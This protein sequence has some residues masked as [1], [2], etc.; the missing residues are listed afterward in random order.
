MVWAQTST[1]PPKNRRLRRSLE[2][3][4][5]WRPPRSSAAG[6]CSGRSWAHWRSFG[7]KT[8]RKRRLTRM[9]NGSTRFNGYVHISPSQRR[10]TEYI[11]V[12]LRCLEVV[13]HLFW[14]LGCVVQSLPEDERKRRLTRIKNGSTRFNEYVRVFARAETARVSHS[15]SFGVV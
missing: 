4:R 6:G 10:A 1:T 15:G 9:Q 13:L 12:L 3:C 2:S 8:R 11:P 5:K 14:A 7:R